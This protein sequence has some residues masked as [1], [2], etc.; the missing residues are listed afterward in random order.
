MSGVADDFSAVIAAYRNAP[1]GQK[2]RLV[3]PRWMANYL[4]AMSAEE[5]EET[6]Q[7]IDRIASGFGLDTPTLIEV[8]E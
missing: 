4:D 7:R 5:R 1:R 6:L 3:I 2:A 8:C